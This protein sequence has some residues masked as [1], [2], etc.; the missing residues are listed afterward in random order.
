LFGAVDGAADAA[1]VAMML[2]LCSSVGSTWLA[3]TLV[4]CS[5][6]TNA[7]VAAAVV[8]E[9]LRYVTLACFFVLV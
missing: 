3:F 7:S 5:W 8:H 4:R 1:S 2:L 6:T 9:W